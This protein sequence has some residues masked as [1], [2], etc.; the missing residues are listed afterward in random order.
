L[1]QWQPMFILAVFAKVE[2]ALR[3]AQLVPTLPYD[4][5]YAHAAAAVEAAQPALPAELL[6]AIAYIESR[7]DPTA[8]SR[9]EGTVRRTGRYP[10]TT[11]PR[12]LRGTLYCGPLQTYAATWTQCLAMR[13]LARAYGAA[14]RELARWVRDPR[15]RGNVGRALLGH[16]CGNVGLRTG[17]CNRY[18]S[19]VLDL[20]RRLAGATPTVP[21]ATS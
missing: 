10:S 8:T 21:S 18:P 17:A 2:L 4:A 11:P 13:D 3:L 19:R 7:F 14:A 12:A 6:L 9:V 20:M 1:L 16:G 5:A 15:V